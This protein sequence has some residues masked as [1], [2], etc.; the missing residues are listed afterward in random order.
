MSVLT[1]PVFSGLQR[2][3]TLASRCSCEI[4]KLVR[5]D[6]FQDFLTNKK[7]TKKKQQKNKKRS[8]KFSVT[9]WL[10]FRQ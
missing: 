2:V 10:G 9:F 8:F 7:T 6:G 1:R 4:G 5:G 3:Q